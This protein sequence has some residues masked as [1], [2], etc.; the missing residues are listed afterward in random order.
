MLVLKPLGWD[1]INILRFH[2]GGY[3]LKQGEGTTLYFDDVWL[4]KQPP[5]ESEEEG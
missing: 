4:S 2:S 5:E 1:Q 3:Q